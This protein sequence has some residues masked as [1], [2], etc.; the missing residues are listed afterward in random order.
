MKWSESLS[1]GTAGFVER[2]QQRLGIQA[3]GRLITWA[4]SF[5][6][7]FCY[8]SDM[9]KIIRNVLRGFGSV[10]SV[11]PGSAPV[12]DVGVSLPS[13]EDALAEDFQRVGEDLRVAT[14]KFAKEHGQEA[15]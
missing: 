8:S 7:S 1:V 12:R 2:I 6:P 3:A 9:T 11:Y 10:G 15:H 13:P 14:R 4:L 5:W